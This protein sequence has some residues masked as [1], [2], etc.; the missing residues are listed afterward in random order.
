LTKS[1]FVAIAELQINP[2]RDRIAEVFSDEDGAIRFEDFIDFLSVFSEEATRDVK[3][4]AAHLLGVGCGLT[5]QANGT[6][7]TP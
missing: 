1:E 3:V 6:H 2:F 5:S 7:C 4:R